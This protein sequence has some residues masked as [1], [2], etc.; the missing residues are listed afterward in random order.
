VKNVLPLPGCNPETLMGYL[1]ALGVF[2]LVALQKDGAARLWWSDE[3]PHLETNRDRGEVS[4]FFLDE[5]T[6]TPFVAPWNGGS[7][8]FQKGVADSTLEL[9]EEAT[10]PRLAEYV[11][12]IQA[13]RACLDAV[14]I[15]GR[16][17][18]SKGQE[19]ARK[20]AAKK[21]KPDLIRECR[22]RLPESAVAA[23]DTVTVLS[24]ERPRFSPLLGAGGGDGNLE[25]TNNFMQRLLDVIPLHTDDA[26]AS[27]NA[28][29]QACGFRERSRAW[30]DHALFAEG[31]YPL[32]GAGIGQFSPGYLGGPNSAPGSWGA[33]LV[34]PWDYVLL[35]EGSVF[36]AGSVT[37]RLRLGARGNAAF[38]F[39]VSVSAAGF[40][41]IGDA[42]ASTGRAEIWLPSWSRPITW[43]EAVHL[44]GEG[45]VDLGRRPA[46]R[47]VDVARAI[48]TLGVDRGISSFGRFAFLAGQRCGRMH[49]A[50]HLGRF[51]VA[52]RAEVGLL[53]EVDAWLG[54]LR[55]AA[56]ATA[57]ASLRHAHRQVEE[58][59]MAFCQHGGARRFQDIVAALGRAEGVLARRRGIRA[60]GGARSG[61]GGS[62]GGRGRTGP[63]PLQG[64]TASRWLQAAD[65]GSP[66]FGLAAA[67]SSVSDSRIGPIRCQLEPVTW[68][69]GRVVWSDSASPGSGVDWAAKP[70][71][72]SGQLADNLGQ[73]LMRRCLEGERHN[74]ERVAVSA[75]VHARLA[76]IQ[77]LLEG[78]VDEQHLEDLIWGMSCLNWSGF[79]GDLSS[80]NIHRPAPALPRPYALLKLLFLPFGL[81]LARGGEQISIGKAHSEV[82]AC[83]LAGRVDDAVT[84]AYRRLLVDGLMPLGY[85]RGGMSAHRYLVSEVIRDRLAA[86]LLVPVS[87]GQAVSLAKMVLRP[88]DDA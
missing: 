52:P 23:L 81:R 10:N 25:F 7:G 40:G 19:N 3:G 39:T 57:P 41:S 32:L 82:L 63:P 24:T 69:R 64:L 42:E 58:S 38:P 36:I 54:S 50:V 17:L 18:P 30:L 46:T 86:A 85:A 33:S 35:M 27:P 14:G 49:L 11:E 5:Y 67:I 61:E 31:R 16:K 4:G 34:N 6:P 68:S 26:P 79:S 28:K 73:V 9:L 45:R 78:A 84:L 75:R 74:L 21:A 51:S 47:G 76:H 59:V 13:A 2:R 72:G 43:G 37:R 8:F 53:D 56:G 55:R 44:F 87:P 15:G 83:V 12:A 66:E 71:W 1:K 70:V 48:A 20:S 65:D 88:E 22:A 60:G 62:D 77:S 80:L 29:G